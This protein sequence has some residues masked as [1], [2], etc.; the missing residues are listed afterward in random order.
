MPG[1]IKSGQGALIGNA[2]EYFVTA[3]LLKRG[4]IAA[5]APRN[6]HSFDILATN[7]AKTIKI[8]VKTKTGPYNVWQWSAKIDGIIFTNLEESDDFTV[9]VNL[10]DETKDMEYYVLPTK[11]LDEWLRKDFDDWV[12]TPGKHGQP[13]A[14]DNPKRNLVYSKFSMQLEPNLNNWDIL[15]GDY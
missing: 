9:L 3:E 1:K 15:W 12:S 5:L 8:R 4:Y 2:G 7:I 6:S 10:T 11:V 13:H 14:L